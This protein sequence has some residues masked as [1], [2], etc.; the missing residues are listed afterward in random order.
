M[1]KNIRY[2]VLYQYNYMRYRK[3]KVQIPFLEIWVGQCCN[4]Y[5]KNCCH[6]IPN[7][8]NRLYD[9]EQIIEDCQ[10]LFMWC[11]VEFFSIVGGE[12]FT[13][14]QLYKLINFVAECSDIKRGKIVTNG[15]ILPQDEMV[16]SLKK[17]HG[18]LEIRIDGYPGIG[19]GVAEKFADIMR[20]N[21]IPY[22]FARFNPDKP[23]SWKQLTPDYNIPLAKRQTKNLFAQCNIRDCNT[24][25][26]GQLT[27]CPRGIGS[28]AV[29]HITKNKYEHINIRELTDS[30]SAKAKIATC[31]DQTIA[32]D[33]CRY[34]LSLSEKNDKYVKPGEQLE[35]K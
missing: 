3:K 27:L 23:S 7:L 32:K 35:K 11:E 20:Q 33:Y 14:S 24:L 19:V 9:I 4:L 30:L 17:L 13:H 26:D 29:F 16:R 5:C 25:A 31:I 6:L 8:E 2:K 15:T 10:K 12:P 1:L 22:H 28:E 21:E 34:C 18:K